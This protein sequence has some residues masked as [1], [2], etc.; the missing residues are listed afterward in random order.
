MTRFGVVLELCHDGFE[1]GL[2]VEAEGGVV[3]VGFLEVLVD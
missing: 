3:E 2:V 1:G